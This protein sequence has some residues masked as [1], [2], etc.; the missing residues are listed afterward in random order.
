VSLKSRSIES[1]LAVS[2]SPRRNGCGDT[3][4]PMCCSRYARPSI[5]PMPAISAL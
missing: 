4:P 1:G 2:R 5:P 3:A